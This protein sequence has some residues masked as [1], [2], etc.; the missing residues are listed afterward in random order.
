[1]E[2]SIL[3]GAESG[4]NIAARNHI[5]GLRLQ[6]QLGLEEAGSIFNKSGFLTDEA[7]ANSDLIIAGERLG[8]K[9]GTRLREILF[10]R[11]G[12]ISDWGKYETQSVMSPIGPYKVHFYYNPVTNDMYFGMDYKTIFNHQGKWDLGLK[13]NFEHE[14]P[15]FDR[16]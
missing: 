15:R 6:Q 14:P 4:V 5:S 12:N 10:K 3:I 2:S 7:I 13:P 1:M 9:G 11:G 8:S 16:S